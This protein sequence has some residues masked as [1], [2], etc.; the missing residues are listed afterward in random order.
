MKWMGVARLLAGAAALLF[1]AM[2][3]DAQSVRGRVLDVATG[4][5]VPG[6]RVVLLG[7][8]GE[9]VAEVVADPAG[10]F[11]VNARSPGDHRIQVE[12]IGYRTATTE[13]FVVRA[14]EQVA[15]EVRLTS[16]PIALDPLNIVGRRADP[17]NEPTLEGLYA[18]R[19]IVP[20]IGNNRVFLPYDPEMAYSR[21]LNDLL[22]WIP[23]QRS[24]VVVYWNGVMVPDSGAAT[25]YL[26]TPI[27]Q[28]EGVEFYRTPSEA[29]AAF[30][31]MPLNLAENVFC[32]VLALWQRTGRYVDEPL[33]PM[34]PAP[35]SWR[36]YA[37]VNAYRLAGHYAPGL[38][39]A[40]EL[41]SQ[42][43]VRGGRLS[44]GPSFRAS[45]H[46]MD[47]A[48]MGE[49]TASLSDAIYR[50]PSGERGLQLYAL[51]VEARLN[52]RE[53]QPT[54]VV[55]GVR[56]EAAQRRFSLQSRRVGNH[57]IGVT[58]YGFGGGVSASVERRLAGGTV[59]NLGVTQDFIRFMAYDEIEKPF[60][61]TAATWSGTGLRAGVVHSFRR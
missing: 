61:P 28:L 53:R 19:H 13:F 33:A 47:Q 51:G 32:A 41:T 1:C 45:V 18:R 38:G 50:I 44:A 59:L 6:A 5:T 20:P 30:R 2:P 22:S 54:Q 8:S 14:T 40:L 56:G 48:L 23:R 17:R 3:A 15:V 49:V 46:R 37:Q 34:P 24:C 27:A 16:A 12:M 43:R 29:P 35:P 9:R 26:E 55:L 4:G 25:Y 60:S 36:H 52:L 57:A 21:D 11:H 42:T 31:E 39:V 58:S 10:R 7:P